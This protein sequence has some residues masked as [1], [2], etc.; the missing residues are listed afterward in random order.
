M[1]GR[2]TLK[3]IAAA[4]GVH[5]STV[6][7]ALNRHPGIPVATRERISAIA[8]GLGYRPDPELASLVAYRTRRRQQTAGGVLAWLD[9]WADRGGA[10]SRFGA[11]WEGS[12]QRAEQLGWKLEV[13]RS[14]RGKIGPKSLTRILRTRA[15]RG[16]FLAPM[17]QEGFT[18]DMDWKEFSAIT[19]SNTLENPS[20]HRVMPHQVHNM[21]IL[22]R[23]LA[24]L[25]YR[26][27][28]LV[29]DAT[30]NERT[31]HYW[32]A[33]FLDAQLMLPTR[34]RILPFI[35]PLDATLPQRLPSWQKKHRPDVIIC[36]NAALLLPIL[37]SAGL[38]VPQDIGLVSQAFPTE[39][40]K[41][42]A[43]G[44]DISG[45]DEC[46]DAIGKIVIDNLVSLIHRHE[47]GIPAEP[48]HIL[49]E[50]RWHGGATVRQ[51]QS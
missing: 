22:M 37:R 17:P 14:Q 11:L 9:M 44:A 2:V 5:V 35:T 38:S 51:Q 24:Q 36:H 16:I 10:A 33:S 45:I 20:L 27:P 41:A 26:H 40:W 28:G 15:I 30:R 50:G 49:I 46:F 7:L 23:H 4:A 6:S 32:T 39:D 13:F 12:Q 34:N 25:G 43:K 48:M 47:R 29:I 18:L 42:P 1:S 31:R 19:C 8:A 3:D 21:Q